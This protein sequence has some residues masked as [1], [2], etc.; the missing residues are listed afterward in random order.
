[1]EQIF[2]TKKVVNEAVS[3]SNQP[4]SSKATSRKYADGMNGYTAERAAEAVEGTQWRHYHSSKGGH[5]FAAEDANALNDRLRGRVVEKC[6]P[7]NTPDGADRIVNGQGIQTKY[8]CTAQKSVEAA[9]D[10][11]TGQYRYGDQLLEVPKDQYTEAVKLME[12]KIRDGKVPGVS[13]PSEASRLVKCGSVTHAEAVRI[14]KA[15]NIDSLK[16]D[17]KNNAVACSCVSGLSF[18]VSFV[19]AK[20]NGASNK[21]ALATAAKSGGKSGVMAMATGVGT[22]QFLRTTT[23]RSVAAS[24]QTVLKKGIDSAMTSKFGRKVVEKTASTIAKKA[25]NGTIARNMLTRSMSTNVVTA[26]VAGVVT[27]IPDTIRVLRGKISP[28]E[29]GKRMASNGAG[30]GGGCAGTWGGAAIGTMVC[31]GIGTAIGG[32]IGGLSGG[33]SASSFVGK[34]FGK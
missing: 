16:F 14:A 22:Q 25:V 13:N 32:F 31:P 2:T 1:M 15:G 8:C 26:T 29:Y 18:A 11:R 34:L 33:I 5:G 19:A 24:T 27:A 3:S 23:G 21:E 10:S 7:D 30:I 4:Q 12:Q 9:F 20:V 17:I 28:K 6:G